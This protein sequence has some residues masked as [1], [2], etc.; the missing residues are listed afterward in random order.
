MEEAKSS[1]TSVNTNRHI[2]LLQKTRFYISATVKY[3]ISQIHQNVR[4]N[5]AIL[6]FLKKLKCIT[7]KCAPLSGVLSPPSLD[8]NLL[9]AVVVVPR[10]QVD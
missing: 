4:S 8:C 3:R 5:E 9:T 10:E 2:V 6:Q 1:E 7:R